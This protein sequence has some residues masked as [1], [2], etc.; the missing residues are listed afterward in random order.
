MTARHPGEMELVRLLWVVRIAKPKRWTVV[1]FTLCSFKLINR[2]QEVRPRL[3]SC[4]LLVF[5]RDRLVAR[6][7]IQFRR[8]PAAGVGHFF[9]PHKRASSWT[10]CDAFVHYTTHGWKSVNLHAPMSSHTAAG[11]STLWYS[12]Y[13]LITSGY[14]F[15]WSHAAR[16][17]ELP[18]PFKTSEAR[19]GET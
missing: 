6:S 11:A 5:Y 14:S 4:W 2:N 9:L 8:P 19:R 13:I 12:P 17:R 1:D 10:K 15:C 3:V 16:A 18:S 7:V